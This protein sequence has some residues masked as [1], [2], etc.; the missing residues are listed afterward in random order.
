MS[1]ADLDAL[2]EQVW[3][4]LMEQ[5]P[6]ALLIGVP[7]E[8]DHNY[9]Y[10][11]EEPYEA[12]ILGDLPPGELLKMPTDPVCRALLSDMPVYLWSGQSYKKAKT[13]RLLCTELA[14]AEKHLRQLGVKPLE[15]AGEN[16]LITAQTARQLL[17]AGARPPKG[18]RLTPLA[19]DIL[20]GKEP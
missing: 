19:R 2:T 15:A 6:R 17:A 8:I 12:V 18:S 20:E 10:V 5:R 4:R 16:R 1:S 13:A 9:N 3:C 7:P 14:A 11:K